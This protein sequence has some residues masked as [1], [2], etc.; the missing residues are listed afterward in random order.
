MQEKKD[1]PLNFLRRT[2]A[3]AVKLGLNVQDLTE[4]IGVSR[5]SLFSYRS[6]LRRI[7]SKAWHKLEA[8]ERR[9]NS[10][11]SAPGGSGGFDENEGKVKEDEIQYGKKNSLEIRLAALERAVMLNPEVARHLQIARLDRAEVVA[12]E[13]FGSV[14][15]LAN[16]ARRA[17]SATKDAKLAAELK[18]TCEEV[19]GNLNE[20]RDWLAGLISLQKNE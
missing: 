6:G 1:T 20:V 9:A 8:A 19:E 13:F 10:E 16:Q 15:H 2:D 17:A 18:F 7:T 5:A 12:R 4:I 3:L 14:K 11:S